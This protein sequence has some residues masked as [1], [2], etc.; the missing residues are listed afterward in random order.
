MYIHVLSP[1]IHVIG[2][3]ASISFY[4]L[5]WSLHQDILGCQA[6]AHDACSRKA[7]VI[8]RN[9]RVAYHGLPFQ[10]FHRGVQCPWRNRFLLSLMS[11]H[12]TVCNKAYSSSTALISSKPHL[13]FFLAPAWR[14][15]DPWHYVPSG[16]LD[17]VAW[18][19][20]NEFQNSQ[21][22]GYK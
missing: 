1:I 16:Q 14:T 22:L 20:R 11:T 4:H 5:L 2:S 10:I 18:S 17:F 3:Q 13:L 21:V 7:H 12:T 15:K 6:H 8:T 9:N 19:E